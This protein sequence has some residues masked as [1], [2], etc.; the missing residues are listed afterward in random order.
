VRDGRGGGHLPKANGRWSSRT[1]APPS[2]HSL[3][4]PI[5]ATARESLAHVR[6]CGDNGDEHDNNAIITE[7]PNYGPSGKLLGY[8]RMRIGGS[9]NAMAKTRKRDGVDEQV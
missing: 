5:A 8:P 9:E 2:I 6:Q 1:R 3:P 4:I 7:I